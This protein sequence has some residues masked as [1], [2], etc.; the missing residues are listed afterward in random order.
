MYY[1]FSYNIV[2]LPLSINFG[3]NVGLGVY[4]FWVGFIIASYT[5][6][7]LLIKEFKKLDWE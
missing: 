1:I 5:C 4:G 6:A 2:G 3:F 7:F